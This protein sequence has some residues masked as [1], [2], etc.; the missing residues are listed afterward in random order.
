M[1]SFVKQIL[2]DFTY[3]QIYLLVFFYF[4]LLYFA[5]APLFLYICKCL[6]KKEILHR[7]V[8]KEVSK[9]QI[10]YEIIHSF[11]SLIIFGFSGI[12]VI[13]LIRIGWI[14]LLP[15]TFFNVLGGIL[16]L[17][18]WN[19][20]HFFV[21]HR[22]MHL[23]YFMRRVHYVHHKSKVPTVYSVYSFHPLESFLL[24]TVPL[25]IA[26]CLPFAPLAIAFYPL[27]SILLNYAGHCNYRFGK[28]AGNSWTLFGTRHNE[29]H[30]KGRRNFGFASDLLDKAY[31]NLKK[32]V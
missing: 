16:I 21:V 18:I 12:P 29:H 32:G 17:T 11:Y 31:Q 19:E 7:I 22:L 28:G 8:D 20:I 15:D 23:P 10:R 5:L 26:V 27:A 9:E 1:H 30:S 6:Q 24:S 3:L 25:T 13:Y 2:F 4:C 14:D